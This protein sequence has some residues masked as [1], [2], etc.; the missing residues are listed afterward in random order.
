M[1]KPMSQFRSFMNRAT[2]K[3]YRFLQLC[4]LWTASQAIYQDQLGKFDWHRQQLGKLE[5]VALSSKKSRLLGTTVEGVVSNIN[6]R[7]G[8]IVWRQKM[9][10]R[11]LDL[12]VYERE[13][14]M[15][16]LTSR[17]MI[18]WDL[19][20]GSA[21]WEVPL[22]ENVDGHLFLEETGNGWVLMKGPNLE[23]RHPIT[24]SVI[25]SI[26]TELTAKNRNTVFL[27]E[28]SGFLYVAGFGEK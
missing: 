3:P 18:G 17:Q 27:T 28:A 7:D 11:I 9:E 6:L 10:D 13:N 1:R 15:L 14:L 8:S 12:F 21:K 19:M 25:W 26:D 22:E 24:G 5:F 20:D 16:T 4:L 2:V 23:L